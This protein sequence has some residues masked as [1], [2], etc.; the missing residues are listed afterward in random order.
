M[1]K[2]GIKQCIVPKNHFKES[3]Y[4]YTYHKNGFGDLS[5][6]YEIPKIKI[7]LNNEEKDSEGNNYTGIIIAASVIG[8]ILIII[9]I[10]LI[11]RCIRKRN[12]SLDAFSKKIDKLFGDE[13]NV[14]LQPGG[15]ILE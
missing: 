1:D 4:Y 13:A 10:F 12:S 2:P 15:E 14:E 3:G 5:I 6:S 9:I 8:I 11:V 7:T